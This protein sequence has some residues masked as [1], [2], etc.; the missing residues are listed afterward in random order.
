[1]VIQQK[2][3]IETRDFLVRSIVRY[4]SFK[5]GNELCGRLIKTVNEFTR[6][7]IRLYARHF[8]MAL[9]GKA[10]NIKAK[11]KSGVAR[12]IL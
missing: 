3:I 12:F 8:T 9:V 7:L 11:G 4:I 6:L 2:N 10:R 1:M 5:E